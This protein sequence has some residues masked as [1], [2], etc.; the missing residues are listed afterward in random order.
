M[1]RRKLLAGIT[2][3]ALLAPVSALPAIITSTQ[4]ATYA[5]GTNA[6]SA[7][8]NGAAVDCR[9]MLYARFAGTITNGGTAPSV[10]ARANMQWSPDNSNWYTIA[11]SPGSLT[12]SDVAP[13]EFQVNEPAGWLRVQITGNTVQSVTYAIANGIAASMQ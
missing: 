13:F 12:N 10:A 5:S 1:N 9:A 11:I 2:A 4:N 7:T 6:G 3:L 8:A